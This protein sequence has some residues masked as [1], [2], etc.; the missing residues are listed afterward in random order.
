LD[1]L[2]EEG[3][4]PEYGARPL[5]RLIQ[6]RVLNELSKSILSNAVNKELP[7]VIDVFDNQVVLREPLMEE[8][9]FAV[10]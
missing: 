9:T 10:N 1:W 6:Q 7:V 5:K 3:Y 2:A 4:H 8:S